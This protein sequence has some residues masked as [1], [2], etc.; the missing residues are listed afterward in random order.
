M[1]LTK[2]QLRRLINE[3]LNEG[4]FDGVKNFF[5]FGA[6]EPKQ[7]DAPEQI[8]GES[9]VAFAVNMAPVSTRLGSVHHGIN[10]VISREF[11]ESEQSRGLASLLGQLQNP[12]V[13]K[14]I[15]STIYQAHDGS[16]GVTM[17]TIT[18]VY[19]ASGDNIRLECDLSKGSP[20]LTKKYKLGLTPINVSE[21]FKHVRMA[22]K[23]PT[24]ALPQHLGV[25]GRIE[26][27]LCHKLFFYSVDPRRKFKR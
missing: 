6:S 16:K 18:G 26:Q 7:S 1:K 23:T 4:F 8:Q 5:G 21:G 10:K 24:Y 15:N 3:S 27:L 11:S 20:Y 22:K 25:D 17:P 12:G 19:A 2:K 14:K 13:L 9:I